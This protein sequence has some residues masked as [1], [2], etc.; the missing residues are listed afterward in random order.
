MLIRTV[1]DKLTDTNNIYFKYT[2]S[3]FAALFLYSRN[4]Y[5]LVQTRISYLLLAKIIIL[6]A[7][8]Y[9]L[10][11]L[12]FYPFPVG[13]ANKDNCMKADVSSNCMRKKFW[14]L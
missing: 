6:K 4:I 1:N 11:S 5:S 14:K 8:T 13:L 7:I 2:I 3:K 10:Y 12:N 9:P